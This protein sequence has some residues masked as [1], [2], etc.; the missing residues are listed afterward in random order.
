MVQERVKSEL[1]GNEISD[2]FKLAK[3]ILHQGHLL[4]IPQIVQPIMWAYGDVF[5]LTPHPDYLVLADD[6][7]DYY[8]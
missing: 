3:T 1:G 2:T 5:H 7:Q 8:H 6:C 4:P